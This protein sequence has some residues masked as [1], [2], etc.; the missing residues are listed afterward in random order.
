VSQ[1]FFVIAAFGIGAAGIVIYFAALARRP[2]LV[3][4]LNGSGLFFTGLAL[5]QAALWFRDTPPSVAWFNRDAAIAV[6]SLA[7]AM[8]SL[9]VLRNRRAWDGEERRGPPPDG[10]PA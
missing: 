4:L 7:V 9:A 1:G 6:L 3:R 8:Q 5:I 10:T 2:N